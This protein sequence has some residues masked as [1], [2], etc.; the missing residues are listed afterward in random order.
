MS[1]RTGGSGGFLQA[2]HTWEAKTKGY[3]SDI[4]YFGN[5]MAKKYLTTAT[6]LENYVGEKYG[7]TMLSY[8]T[9]GKK[10]IRGRPKPLTTSE[11]AN[12]DED[13]KEI[14]KLLMRSFVGKMTTLEDHIGKVYHLLLSHCHPSL[15]R[16]SGWSK[17]SLTS[18]EKRM[19]R[20]CGSSSHACATATM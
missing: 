2:A 17:P 6:N 7:T 18:M 16:G 13:D 1:S 4:F 8:M 14:R 20:N 11:A 5:G 9:T 10:I 3:T 19:Q 15:V 12:Q